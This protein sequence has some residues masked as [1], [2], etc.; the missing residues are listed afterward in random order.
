MEASYSLY[1]YTKSI[2]RI[3]EILDSSDASYENRT[4]IPPRDQLTFNNGFYVDVTVVFVDMRGSKA[5]AEK[6]TRPVLAKIYRAYI[7]EVVSVL[8]GDQTI[9]EIY[10]EGD[11]VWAVFDTTTV[12]HVDSVFSTVCRVASLT[13]ILNVKLRKKGYSTIKVGIGVDD[14]ESLYIKAGYKGA[15]INE[16]VWIGKVVGKSAALCKDANRGL[17]SERIRVSHKVYGCLNDHNKSLLTYMP[18]ADCYQG[19]AINIVMNQWV[20]DNG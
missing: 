20:Q 3:T 6:H 13:D 1:D 15:A 7:S 14:G 5:L 16:V 4:G 8:R 12:A 10:I 2:E 19:N 18:S 11:G 17:F 9:N